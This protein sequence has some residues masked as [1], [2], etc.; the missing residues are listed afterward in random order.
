MDES[1][2]GER[3][4]SAEI[5]T[6]RGKPIQGVAVRSEY[7]ELL[8]KQ[9]RGSGANVGGVSARKRQPQMPPEVDRKNTVRPA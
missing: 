3:D 5:I 4:E 2:A 1:E 6:G 7:W 9:S 8:A